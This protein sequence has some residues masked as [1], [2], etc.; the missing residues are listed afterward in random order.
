MMNEIKN[1]I[2]ECKLHIENFEPFPY[3]YDY[4]SP[5]CF[6]ARSKIFVINQSGEYVSM[7]LGELQVGSRLSETTEVNGIIK[8]VAKIG[9]DLY[10][11][12][13]LIGTG[14]H[15]ILHSD[16]NWIFFKN[17]PDA[18]KFISEEEI[19]LISLRVK[20]LISQKN[21][22]SV[23]IEGIACSTFGHGH[24]DPN[25]SSPIDSPFW[26]KQLSDW[27]DSQNISTLIL[28]EETFLLRNDTQGCY[29]IVFNGIYFVHG[30]IFF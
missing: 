11:V 20:D 8:S 30:G 4:P 1:L 25:S 19:T 22:S 17:H 5:G 3:I 16:G 27:M 15:P 12:G 9:S 2:H 18:K 23:S 6:D 29:G 10:Q 14:N 26:G 21:I 28:N 7:N 24:I 13:L